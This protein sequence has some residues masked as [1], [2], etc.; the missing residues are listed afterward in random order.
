MKNLKIRLFGAPVLRSLGVAGFALACMVLLSNVAQGTL[1]GSA[2]KNTNA[3]Q[4]TLAQRGWEMAKRNRNNI[5][6]L[7]GGTAAAT[8]TSFAARKYLQNRQQIQNEKNREQNLLISRIDTMIRKFNR[9]FNH[10]NVNLKPSKKQVAAVASA[11]DQIVDLRTEAFNIRDTINSSVHSSKPAQ[12]S[13]TAPSSNSGPS[14]INWAWK[15]LRH[16]VS[17]YQSWGHTGTSA[18]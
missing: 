8:G 9:L 4:Q 11:L 18:E 7:A 17:T 12:F 15:A 16:P 10:I 6:A 3:Q 13:E 1:E 5:G 2:R 14:R